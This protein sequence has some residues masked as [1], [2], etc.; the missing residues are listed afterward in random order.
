MKADTETLVFNLG[1]STKLHRP[2][3]YFGIKQ[4]QYSSGY[5]C[6][7]IIAFIKHLTISEWFENKGNLVPAYWFTNK[8]VLFFFF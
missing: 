6:Y 7:G 5:C 3:I 1:F 2:I 8:G 4:R